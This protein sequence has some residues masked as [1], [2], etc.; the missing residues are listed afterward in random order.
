MA[1]GKEGAKKENVLVCFLRVAPLPQHLAGGLAHGNEELV[2][3]E[4]LHHA[5]EQHQV[6]VGDDIEPQQVVLREE[7][8]PG[9]PAPVVQRLLP[10]GQLRRFGV[11]AAGRARRGRDWRRHRGRGGRDVGSSFLLL[12][13]R[14]RR[15][16]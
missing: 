12:A 15:G 6:A 7:V 13:E 4:G 2:I 1:Q 11:T 3:A 9:L 10:D 14:G 16:G 5:R 8:R